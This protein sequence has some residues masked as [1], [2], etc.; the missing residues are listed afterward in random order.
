MLIFVVILF[1]MDKLLWA[2]PL[3]NFQ[4]TFTTTP[5]PKPDGLPKIKNILGNPLKFSFKKSRKYLIKYNY[6]G[7]NS[8]D[9]VIRNLSDTDPDKAQRM[10]LEKF[11][12][13]ANLKVSRQ[14]DNDTIRMMLWPRCGMA[15]DNI[16]II[17]NNTSRRKRFAPVPWGQQ[18]NKRLLTYK[19]K[20]YPVNEYVLSPKRKKLVRGPSREEIHSAITEAF[21]VWSRVSKL[22]FQEVKRNA[23]INLAFTNRRHGDGF[24]FDGPNGEI[25][26]AFFPVWGGDVH[27]DN[28]EAWSLD[29]KGKFGYNVFQVAVH[30]LGHSL[31]LQHVKDRE[32][33]MYPFYRFRRKFELSND[34]IAG[35]NYLYP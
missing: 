30:E 34:D 2:F 15:D 17:G 5:E 14:L 1:S 16:E 6:L 3:T 22:R 18:W 24:P 33:I 13:F 35:L 20:K 12:Q 10:A 19:I 23:D 11:Q 9:P 4:I 31:G 25:A 8:S 32:S 7:P 26:H 29:K 21:K 28:N 27:F